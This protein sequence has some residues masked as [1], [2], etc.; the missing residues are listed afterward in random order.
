[1]LLAGLHDHAGDRPLRQQRAQRV[2]V[3]VGEAVGELPHGGGHARVERQ[4]AD[5]PVLAAEERLRAG[6][7]VLAAGGRPGQPHRRGGGVGGVLGELHHLRA[8]R[9]WPRSPRPRRAPS[10]WGGRT[11]PRRR[12]PRARPRPP[13]R[14]RARG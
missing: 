13:A 8:A 2:E 1:M 12:S 9:P 7:D 10:R 4:G 3:V 14:S 11:R 6:G 5:E